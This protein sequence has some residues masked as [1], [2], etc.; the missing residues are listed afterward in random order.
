MQKKHPTDGKNMIQTL[1]IF[2]LIL[3]DEWLLEGESIQIKYGLQK[4]NT[5]KTHKWW[6]FCNIQEAQRHSS[7]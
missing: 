7:T 2:F 5:A 3:L 1:I 4:H 6:T